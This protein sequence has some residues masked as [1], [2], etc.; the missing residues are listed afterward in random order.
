MK[1]VLIADDSAT[2]RDYLRLLLSRQ[3]QFA[4]CGEAVDGEDAVAK[5]KLLDPDVVLLDLAMPKMNGAQAACVLRKSN[6]DAHLVLSTMHGDSVGRDLAAAVGVHR[7]ISKQGG[8][9]A[10]IACI[11]GLPERA[12]SKSV[13]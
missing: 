4:V 3:E 2:V 10:L 12:V 8:V 7:V 5:A 9:A 11:E 6:P 13:N 1:R